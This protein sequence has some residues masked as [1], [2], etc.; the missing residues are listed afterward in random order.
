MFCEKRFNTTFLRTSKPDIGGFKSGL[1]SPDIPDEAVIKRGTQLRVS[2][3]IKLHSF[4]TCEWEYLS[5]LVSPSFNLT[6][7]EPLTNS[8]TYTKQISG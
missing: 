7:A 6:V 5:L 1:R 8:L 2:E 4:R 3:T